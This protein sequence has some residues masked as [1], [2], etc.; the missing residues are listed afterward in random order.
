MLVTRLTFS[1]FNLLSFSVLSPLFSGF[2]SLPFNPLAM[3]R[4]HLIYKPHYYSQ[5]KYPA[6]DK[7]KNFC[8]SAAIMPVKTKTSAH[9]C[10]STC[11]LVWL[12]HQ[13]FRII[14]CPTLPQP[15]RGPRYVGISTEFLSPRPCT[16]IK[17]TSMVTTE[18]KRGTEA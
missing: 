12:V 5:K 17:R 13:C 8:C 3:F 16:D 7:H 6:Q 15:R 11:K 4:G 18:R 9:H 2:I 1:R 14:L 10:S